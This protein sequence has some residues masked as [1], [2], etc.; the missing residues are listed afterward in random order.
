LSYQKYKKCT[1]SINRL[2]DVVKTNALWEKYKFGN[3]GKF[4]D[5]DFKDE[6]ASLFWADAPNNEM[7]DTYKRVQEWRRPS[8]IMAENGDTETKP[9]LW[10]TD[11]EQKDYMSGI[12]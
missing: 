5:P 9:S 1:K 6:Q 2:H 10:G 7:Y 11:P 4:F 3:G 8:E 12:T